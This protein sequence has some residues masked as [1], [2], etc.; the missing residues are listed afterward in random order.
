[1]VRHRVPARQAR[2]G[3]RLRADQAEERRVRQD[4]R[5][6]LQR[7]HQGRDGQRRQ[8]HDAV[9]LQRRHVV[10]VHGHPDLRPDRGLARRRRRRQELHAREPGGDRGL[11]RRPR[12]L[13]R[14]AGLGRARGHLHR[15]GPAGR[16]LDRRHQAG[17][18][19]DRRHRAGAAVHHHRRADQGGHARLVLPGPH[20]LLDDSTF[21]GPQAGARRPV[22]RRRARRVRARGAR[23]PRSPTARDR[24]TTTPTTLVRGVVAEQE[25]IDALLAEHA[26]GWTPRPDAGGRPQRAAARGLRDP[27]RRRRAGRRRGVRGGRAGAGPVDRRVAGVRQRRPRRGPPQAASSAADRPP[28]PPRPGP[29]PRRRPG[30]SRRGCRRPGWCRTTPARPS[31]GSAPS[32]RSAP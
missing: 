17:H 9:P 19:R 3:P 22:R 29:R 30:W 18:R 25:R 16:P 20:Q 6:D 2:Q 1:M 23:R 10:R 28:G 27:V 14:A 13:R 8:A 15:A 31:G 26:Q 21:E 24:P 12:P 11:Q 5:Q 32:S 7:R 4:R